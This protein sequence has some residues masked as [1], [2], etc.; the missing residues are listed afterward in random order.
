MDDLLDL[1]L[2]LVQAGDVLEGH[3]G[4]ILVEEACLAL[5]D[6][7]RT[8]HA[9]AH[10]TGLATQHD[11]PEANDDDQRE[12]VQHEAQQSRAALLILYACA[13]GLLL[14]ELVEAV[15]ARD[16]SLDAARA[17][18]L[19]TAEDGALAYAVEAVGLAGAQHPHSGVLASIDDDLA[20]GLLLG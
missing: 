20:E 1:L 10:S 13:Y 7:Q 11:D 14:V 8:A 4:G 2:G 16:L 5:T 12:E 18:G 19:D 3:R 15:Y 17:L 6:A 9:A